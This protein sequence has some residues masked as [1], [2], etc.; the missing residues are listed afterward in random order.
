MKSGRGTYPEQ[1]CPRPNC[2]GRVRYAVV[3]RQGRLVIKGLD[4]IRC[5]ANHALTTDERQ[6]LQVQW[7]RAAAKREKAKNCAI[8]SLAQEPFWL[9]HTKE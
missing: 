9:T 6:W 5:S 8:S 4:T 2:A 3:K 7:N 1:D